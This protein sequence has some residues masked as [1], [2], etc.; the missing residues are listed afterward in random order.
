LGEF[1]EK[2]TPDVCVRYVIKDTSE[3]GEF[4]DSVQR[5]YGFERKS[6]PL[7]YTIEGTLI[8]DGRAFIEH[9]REKYGKTLTVTKES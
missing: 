5:S 8:G 3:W 2:S 7:V 9:V 4:V 6:C 1:L